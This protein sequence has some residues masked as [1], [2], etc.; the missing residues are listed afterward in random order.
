MRRVCSALSLIRSR[1]LMVRIG[2]TLRF[3]RALS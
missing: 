1:L 2:V 3:L